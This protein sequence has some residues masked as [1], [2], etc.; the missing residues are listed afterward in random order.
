MEHPRGNKDS[1]LRL[2]KYGGHIYG[3][4]KAFYRI[5]RERVTAQVSAVLSLLTRLTGLFT[6][7][8]EDLVVFSSR[9]PSSSLSCQGQLG[10]SR[11]WRVFFRCKAHSF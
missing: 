2:A 3:A 5:G 7:P 9:T 10:S 11:G 4:T 6:M 1:E 8:E